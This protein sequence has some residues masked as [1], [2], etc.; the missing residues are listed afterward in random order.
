[1]LCKIPSNG[2]KHRH[3]WCLTFSERTIPAYHC[4]IFIHSYQ[5]DIRSKYR[6]I[7]T[8]IVICDSV[9]IRKKAQVAQVNKILVIELTLSF[10]KFICNFLALGDFVCFV[11]MKILIYNILSLH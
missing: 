4:D 6:R 10:L 8:L 7:F 9:P 11:N 2:W 3:L 5:S 1:M